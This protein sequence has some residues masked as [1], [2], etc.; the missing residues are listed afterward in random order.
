V[1]NDLPLAIQELTPRLASRESLGADEPR[2]EPYFVLVYLACA[3][4][5]LA[6][7]FSLLATLALA[8]MVPWYLLVA[9]PVVR[10]S[11]DDWL[12]AQRSWRPAVFLTGLTALFAIVQWHSPNAWFLAFAFSPLCFLITTQRRG[13]TFV[14]VLNV[15]AGTILAVRSKNAVE[16]ASAI[17]IAIFAIAF[18]WVFSRWTMHV[19]LRSLERQ[20]LIEQLEATRTEL[21]AAHHNAGVLAERQRLA[22]EIHDTLAQGFT[23]IITLIQA[24]RATPGSGSGRH[25]D[26]ALTTARENLVEARAL[27]AALS[28]AQLNDGTLGD[29][30]CRA[31]QTAGTELGIDCLAEVTGTVRALPM[32]AEVVLL[33][34]CQEALA[35][36]RKHAAASSASVRLSYADEAVLLEVADDGR[37]FD[38]AADSDGY[39]L[40]GMRTR[41]GQAGGTLA[42]RTAPGAGTAVTAEVPA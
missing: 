3:G 35:N 36:V 25:L 19:V 7:R 41:V 32:A 42:V 28:P 23:S 17:G 16:T 30:V 4:I 15:T 11:Y 9:R 40:R 5:V 13:M 12:V 26:M 21:A 18:S 22:G 39:G 34:V 37:G 24:A 8:A 14:V 1:P 31:A 33:R 6:G 29:A 10:L 20:A 2:W 38:A 27:V